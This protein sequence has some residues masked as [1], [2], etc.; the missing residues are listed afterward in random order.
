MGSVTFLDLEDKLSDAIL[1][2]ARGWVLRLAED[3]VAEAECTAWRAADP[4]HEQAWQEV[5]AVWEQARDLPLLTRQ[6]WR[7][8]VEALTQ[9]TR[10]WL[11]PWGLAA[12]AAVAGIVG[13]SSYSAR[14]DLKASTR[15]AETRK[16]ALADGSQVTLGAK[17]GVEVRFDSASRRV[18]LD[19]GQAFFEVAHDRSRPFT[20]IAGDAEIRVTGTKFDVRR[21]GN[22]VQV[23]VLEGRVEVRRRGLLSIL[24]PQQPERVL[25]AGLETELAPGASQFTPEEKADVKPGQWRSGRLYYSETRLGDIVA[26][27]Q[28]Y[29][30]VPIRIED[31]G[32]A[33]LRLTTSFRSDQIGAFLTDLVTTTP[34]AQYRGSD[35]AV[36]L[37]TRKTRS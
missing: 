4:A 21:T 19:H 17:T 29:S 22:D 9:P 13:V 5:S 7:A 36:V 32:V 6:D 14:P 2:D 30:S 23:S 34:V 26:D 15:V 3:P 31:P 1:A 35:G 37:K 25:T 24:T 16:V 8:E 27:L 11:A 20:V 33:N 18:V 12:A 28:R 10:R